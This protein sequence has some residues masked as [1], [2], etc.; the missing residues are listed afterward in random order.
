MH[1][2]VYRVDPRMIPPIIMA[3]VFGILIIIMEGATRR[4]FLSLAL[5]APFYYLGAEILARKIVIG[6][7]GIII[8]KFLRSLDLNWNGIDSLDMVRSGKKVFLILQ[9]GENRPV[10]ITNTIQNFHDLLNQLM[11]K[12]P[13][14]KI[15]TPVKELLQDPPSKYGPLLQA[16][17]IC[18][19][20][21]GIVTGKILGY[22]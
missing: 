14:E 3:M 7:Q 19:V 9:G 4:G 5:L 10:L 16:W 8:K 17:L 18:I 20:L 22:G 15:S 1:N 2:S 6:E 13:E 11:R 21:L 12:I